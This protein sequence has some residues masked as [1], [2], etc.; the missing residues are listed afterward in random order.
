MI[1]ELGLAALWLAAGLALAQ[2]LLALGLGGG[3]GG[4]APRA[5]AMVQAVLA[6]IAF[7]AL[8]LAGG[9]NYTIDA[10]LG[11]KG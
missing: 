8:I 6:G 10:K 2:L 7:L 3:E 1:A 5:L 9:G 4:R 11:A